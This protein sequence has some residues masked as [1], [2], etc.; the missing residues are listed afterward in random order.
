MSFLIVWIDCGSTEVRWPTKFWNRKPD[1]VT[2]AVGE[3]FTATLNV[4]QVSFRS[5]LSYLSAKI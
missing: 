4:G 3:E 2:I 1:R 5:N